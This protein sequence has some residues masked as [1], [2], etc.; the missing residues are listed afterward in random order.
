MI[1]RQQKNEIWNQLNTMARNRIRKREKK[2]FSE[3]PAKKQ[4]GK[5]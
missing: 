2:P 5:R 3:K 1:I 4:S